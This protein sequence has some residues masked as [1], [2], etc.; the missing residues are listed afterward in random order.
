MSR[1]IWQRPWLVAAGGVEGELA[2]QG[3]VPAEDADIQVG[4]EDDYSCSGVLS[5]NADVVEL[6]ALPQGD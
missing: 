2:Q 3:G 6:A 1:D 5:A 4:D